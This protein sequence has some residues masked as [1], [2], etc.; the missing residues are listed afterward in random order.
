MHCTDDDL[1]LHHYGDPE[2]SPDVAAHVAVCGSCRE[3]AADLEATLRTAVF[4]EV[5][6][7]GPQYEARLWQQLEPRLELRRPVF[8]ISRTRVLS[9]AAAAALLLTVGF[10]AGRSVPGPAPR[11]TRAA[12]DA[13]EARR[14]LLMSVADHLDRS[15]RVLT[16]IMNA[17]A[18]GDIAAEQQWAA[19]LDLRQPVLSAGCRG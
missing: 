10:M 5:P 9:L 4:P 3:R 19:D 18:D 2:A 12:L 11:A 6:D 8:T 14:V 16:D 17:S 1:V 13:G 7:P 15:D